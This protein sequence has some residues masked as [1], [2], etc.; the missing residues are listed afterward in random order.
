MSEL[1]IPSL[2]AEFDA[3]LF[4]PERERL[5]RGIGAL[6]RTVGAK[7]LFNTSITVAERESTAWAEGRMIP[8]AV[9]IADLWRFPTLQVWSCRYQRQSGIAQRHLLRA[10]VFF[11]TLREAGSKRKAVAIQAFAAEF[12]YGAKVS[13]LRAQRSGSSC[14][15]VERSFYLRDYTVHRFG[16]ASLAREMCDPRREGEF[17]AYYPDPELP[18]PHHLLHLPALL[19]LPEG[20]ALAVQLRAVAAAHAS[21]LRRLEARPQQARRNIR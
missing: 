4:S 16:A 21:D 2:R 3:W 19:P 14:V 17:G 10:N 9:L 13:V 7:W 11:E 18:Q 6:L 1:S 12:G 15:P 8:G 20:H 5:A